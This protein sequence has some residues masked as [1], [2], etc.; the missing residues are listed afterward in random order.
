MVSLVT[1]AK[2]GKPGPL[3]EIVHRERKWFEKGDSDRPGG[4]S[5]Q[6]IS[7][8]R[9]V[10][11][12]AEKCEQVSVIAP[13]CHI[14]GIAIQPMVD[15]T[16]YAAGKLITTGYLP[17]GSM[18][19]NEPGLPRR[20]IFRGA[21]DVLHLHIPNTVIAEYTDP[22]C[23]HAR[24]G[25][26]ISELPT[27]DPVIEGLARSLIHAEEVGGAF[28]QTYADGISVAIT[29]RLVGGSTGGVV[30]NDRHVSALPKWR[31]KRA[32]EYMMANL[33]EPIGLAD[34]AAAAGLSRMHFAQQFRA[35]TGLRPHEYLLYRRIERAQELLSNSRESLVQIAL[36]V[37]F[38][39]QSHFTSVFARLVHETPNVWRLHNREAA[40]IRRSK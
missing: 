26:L 9:W 16:L 31:L 25:P 14:V 2:S 4:A 12:T 23:R 8:S 28:G 6:R 1:E 24:R 5:G 29:A 21:Y 10:G 11:Y 30:S 22:V 34:I 35:T 13:D 20:G 15:V 3:P 19:I 18:R 36:D 33:A 39:T 40:D 32:T 38:K 37:G 7:A 27:V 17:R